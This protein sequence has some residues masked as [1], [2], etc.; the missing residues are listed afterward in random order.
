MSASPE[1]IDDEAYRLFMVLQEGIPLTSRPYAMMGKMAGL[2][3]KRVM[4]RLKEWQTSGLL[5]RI[6]VI[7]RHR[8]LGYQAN[9]MVVFDIPDEKVCE[10]ANSILLESLV[11]LCYLRP[12][13][14]PEW[15]YNLFCMIHGKD[16]DVVNG[17]IFELRER[18][19]LAAHPHDVLFSL[20][21]FKQRGARYLFADLQPDSTD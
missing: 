16:R 2:S 9:A 4:E 3:E 10:Y 8:A 21:C 19:G 14:P 11:T 5:K 15:P 17:K 20:K 13:R 6:G 12:R 18:T 1:L 7:V